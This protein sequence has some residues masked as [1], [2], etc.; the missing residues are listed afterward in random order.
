MKQVVTQVL[1]WDDVH[2]AAGLDVEAGHTDVGLSWDGKAVTLDLAAEHYRE[3]NAFL[4]PYLASGTPVKG[5]RK[6]GAGP[7]APPPY[8]P[9]PAGQ[10]RQPAP[11]Y[12]DRLM[13]SRGYTTAQSGEYLR[14]LRAWADSQGRTDEYARKLDGSPRPGTKKYYPQQLVKDYEAAVPLG[15]KEPWRERAGAA[16]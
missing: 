14:G 11:S 12:V 7:G 13:R 10:G 16:G 6:R 4:A 8:K 3:V 2:K 5:A 1:I 9:A 15:Q